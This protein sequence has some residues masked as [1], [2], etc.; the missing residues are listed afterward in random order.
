MKPTANQIKK[1]K[2]DNKKYPKHLIRLD[3]SD[4]TCPADQIEVWRSR[5]FFVQIYQENDEVLRLSVNRTLV[6]GNRFKD[7]ISWDDLQRLKKECGY[8]HMAAVEIYPP[9]ES[10]VNVAN[11]RHLFILQTPPD[12]MW[13][14][15][16]NRE[17]ETKK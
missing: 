10:V 9:D 11:M 3:V 4:R 12:F 6:S 15:S 14:K 1:L 8:S 2:R 5:D 7:D 17:F 13:N 16:P